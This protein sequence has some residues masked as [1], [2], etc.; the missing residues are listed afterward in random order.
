VLMMVVEAYLQVDFE[1]LMLMVV[2]PKM[3]DDDD[4]ENFSMYV[5]HEN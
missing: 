3:N 4:D 2:E 1:Y 5:H